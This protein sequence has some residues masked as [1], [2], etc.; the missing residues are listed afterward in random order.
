MGIIW[1]ACTGFLSDFTKMALKLFFNT[2]NMKIGKAKISL[3]FVNDNATY[4]F[5]IHEVAL[6]KR[7][8]VLH[9]FELYKMSLDQPNEWLVDLHRVVQNKPDTIKSRVIS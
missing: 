6:S 5:P 8:Q 9:T 3:S 1:S 2:S 4:L 7:I